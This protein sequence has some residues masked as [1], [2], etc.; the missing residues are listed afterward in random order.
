[1][2]D[3]ADNVVVMEQGTIVEEGPYHALMQREK[4]KLRRLIDD[5]DARGN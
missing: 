5:A 1:M 4:G 3:I 2:M